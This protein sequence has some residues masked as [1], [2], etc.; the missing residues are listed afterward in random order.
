MRYAII[1]SLAALAVAAPVPQDDGKQKFSYACPRFSNLLQWLRSSLASHFS[2]LFEEIFK[3]HV[4]RE[5]PRLLDCSTGR[6]VF[7]LHTDP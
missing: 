5:R 6:V 1:I 2:P 4:H 3:A 7:K